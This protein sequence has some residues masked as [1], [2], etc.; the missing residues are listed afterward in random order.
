MFWCFNTSHV[1][2]LKNLPI[3]LF[4]LKCYLELYLMQSRTF[5]CFLFLVKHPYPFNDQLVV[6]IRR[7]GP[8]VSVGQAWQEGNVLEQVPRKLCSEILMVKD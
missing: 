6:Y 3:P 7:L 8:G 1:T 2:I 5:H 4:D